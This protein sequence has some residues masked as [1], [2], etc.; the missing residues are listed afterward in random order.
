MEIPCI[1]GLS[2][3]AH[4]PCSITRKI[5][6]QIMDNNNEPIPFK[7]IDP[8]SFVWNLIL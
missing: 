7:S 6:L 4:N 3:K 2:E 5:T 1:S 8:V